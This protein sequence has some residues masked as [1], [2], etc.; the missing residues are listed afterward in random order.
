M[1][2]TV[3]MFGCGSGDSIHDPTKSLTNLKRRAMK[4]TFLLTLML[5]CI[6][7][8]ELETG[9]KGAPKVPSQRPELTQPAEQTQQE[10][11]TLTVTAGVETAETGLNLETNA[12]PASS[13]SHTDVTDTHAETALQPTTFEPSSLTNVPSNDVELSAR[14][15]I[16]LA[17][18]VVMEKGWADPSAPL[19]MSA[20]AESTNWSA[21]FLIPL[22]TDADYKCYVTLAMDQARP[23]DVIVNNDE[24]AS[25]LLFVTHSP[26]F[27]ST[28][29]FFVADVHLT[30]GTN[31]I[32]LKSSVALAP[33]IAGISLTQTAQ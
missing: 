10:Q 11:P 4:T 9:E 21:T 29:R 31:T 33:H 13:P 17:S 8:C 5:V 30:E 15:A 1:A 27:S 24:V 7:G 19:I 16:D 28:K 14:S 12:P 18:V 6:C 2:H 26:H 25:D 32:T 23:F 22:A 3:A 20:S